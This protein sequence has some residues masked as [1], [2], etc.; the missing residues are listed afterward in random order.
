MAHVYA[1]NFDPSV[2]RAGYIPGT[3][4]ALPYL[5][6]FS[7]AHDDE[8]GMLRH[9]NCSLL[10]TPGVPPTLIALKQ[11]AQSLAYLIAMLNPH[12][13]DDEAVEVLVKRA[14]AAKSAKR[15]KRQKTG[16]IGDDDTGVTDGSL[17]RDLVS[18]TTDTTTDNPFDWLDLSRP[19]TNDADPAHHRPLIDLVNEVK[20]RHDVLDTTYHCPLTTYEPRNGGRYTRDRSKGKDKDDARRWDEDGFDQRRPY[21][22]YHGLLLHANMCLERLDHEYAATGGLLSLL[23]TRRVNGVSGDNNKDTSTNRNKNEDEDE[24]EEAPEIKAARNTLVG[25]WIVFSQNLIGRTYELEAAYANAVHALRGRDTG[26]DTG[27]AAD[28][29]RMIHAGDDVWADVHSKLD[30]SSTADAA[31][32]AQRSTQGVVGGNQAADAAS[33]DRVVYVDINTRFYRTDVGGTHARGAIYVCPVGAPGIVDAGVED[34]SGRGSSAAA[35]DADKRADRHAA[36]G[37]HYSASALEQRYDRRLQDAGRIARANQHLAEQ[38]LQHAQALLVL[39]R[40]QERMLALNA[41][42]QRTAD[43]A[44]QRLKTAEAELADLKSTRGW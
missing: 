30:A 2:H 32:T 28:K 27:A 5:S 3:E 17:L 35:D 20:A 41:E 7:M 24:D 39:R 26:A 10:S 6:R 37:R 33:A 43:A 29:W 15:A 16:H 13:G 25:Q 12:G 36:Q 38:A 23:P 22:S 44:R 9:V 14:K 19:Y 1:H 4:F 42:L 21:A 8:A 11:H 34:G 40:D 31:W 18:G